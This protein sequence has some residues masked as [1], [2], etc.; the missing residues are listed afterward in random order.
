M[1]V[2]EAKEPTIEELISE[3]EKY[4]KAAKILPIKMEP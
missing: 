3:V 1:L 4:A 2:A